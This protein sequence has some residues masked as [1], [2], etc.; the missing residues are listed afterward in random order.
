[1]SFCEYLSDHIIFW[2]DYSISFYL[3]IDRNRTMNTHM[4]S[5]CF[6]LYEYVCSIDLI[7]FGGH[8]SIEMKFGYQKVEFLERKK[9][10]FSWFFLFYF[11]LTHCIFW[12]YFLR[13]NH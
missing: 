10:F 6:F 2:F 12:K 9:I 13:S 11:T 3:K 7:K 5:L 1:M 8:F 4:M